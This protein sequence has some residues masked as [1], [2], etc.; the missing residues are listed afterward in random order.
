MPATMVD[1]EVIR[2]AVRLACRAPSLHNS[3]PWRWVLEGAALQLFADAHRVV[4]AT[5]SS[6]REALMACGAVLDHFRVAMAAAGYTANVD[7]FP[8]PNNRL[9]VASVDFTPMNYVTDGHRRR[10]NAILLRRTDRLPFAAPSDWDAFESALRGTVTSEAVRLDT[11]PDDLRPQLAEA[12]QLTES[13]RLYDSSYHAELEWW[14]AAFEV[15]EGIPHSSLV[16]AAESDRVDVGRTFP[17]THHRERRPEVDE[18]RAKVLVLST[19]DDTRESVL[20]CG[21]SLSAALLDAT[22]VGLATCTLTH[23]TEVPASRAILAGLIDQSNRG[24]TPQVLI[25]VGLTPSIENLPPPTPRRPMS[26]LFEVRQ[27]T[28]SAQ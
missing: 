19:Y 6:G 3:Q 12:S 15:S 8:N 4:R 11:I 10:A 16:S 24:L 28:K 20:R 17:V 27:E 18:D 9:H 1:T 25:R 23:I 5:D 14:T 26:E 7:R 2:N 13:L 21:E 22:T